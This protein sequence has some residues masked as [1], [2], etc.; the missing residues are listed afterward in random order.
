MDHHEPVR[1]NRTGVRFRLLALGGVVAVLAAGCGGSS[2]PST[3]V[4]K[5]KTATKIAVS[6]PKTTTKKA[7]S[8]AGGSTSTSSSSSAPTFASAGNCAQ[9]AGVGSQFAKAIAAAGSG[10]KYNLS[11]AVA[12][13]RA[14]ANAAPSAIRPDLE[15]LT[16]AFTAYAQAVG[17]AGFKPGQ[18]PSPTQIAGIEAAAKQFSDTKLLSAAKGIES[19]AAK[20]CSA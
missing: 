5:K 4:T 2:T 3:T 15:T 9:L 12:A 6:K 13:Y 20:N 10:G 11:A 14:L 7:P 17:K 16:S 18:V 8:G 19:W 1:A